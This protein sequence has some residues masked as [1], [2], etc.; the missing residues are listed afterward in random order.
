[1]RRKSY[2]IGAA[3]AASGNEN[4]VDFLD[5]FDATENTLSPMESL[6]KYEKYVEDEDENEDEGEELSAYSVESVYLQFVN[7]LIGSQRG[8][9]R[10][11]KLVRIPSIHIPCIHANTA[12][13]TPPSTLH[14]LLFSSLSSN[15]SAENGFSQR[16][17]SPPSTFPCRGWHYTVPSSQS[18]TST[19]SLLM[20]SPFSI[21]CFASK[22]DSSSQ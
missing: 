7:S 1:M 15:S 2:A 12:R 22:I 4:P 20:Q 17:S 5:Q 16:F 6:P 21:L 8:E 11:L 9:E 13:P 18:S 3:V 10:P 19:Q 14:G